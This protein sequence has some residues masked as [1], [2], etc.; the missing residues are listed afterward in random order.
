MEQSVLEIIGEQTASGATIGTMCAIAAG[1]PVIEIG[2]AAL[3]ARSIVPVTPSDVGRDVLV[4]F[5]RNDPRRPIVIGFVLDAPAT[6]QTRDVTIDGDRLH[7][8]GRKEIT[9][10]CGEGSIVM[11]NDGTVIVKGINVTTRARGINKVKGAAVK[12]N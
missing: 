9:L 7:I 5:E 6:S 8:D 10:A 11:R 3:E 12:I 2:D 1:R 4:L